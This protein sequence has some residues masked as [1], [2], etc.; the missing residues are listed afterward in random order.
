MAK[1]SELKGKIIVEESKD[2][3]VETT[4]ANSDIKKVGFPSFKGA[5]KEK[6]ENSLDLLLD[7]QM[8]VVVELGRTVLKIK[9]ILELGPG[10]IIELD[11]LSGEPVDI[12]VNGS[13][14]AKGEVVVIDEN[15]AIRISDVAMGK[16]DEG[17]DDAN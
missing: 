12:L 5:I 13:L 11:K 8:K 3:A 14:V 15:F 1:S 4:Q 9:D 10:S 17:T 6:T 7:I 16:P 2:E